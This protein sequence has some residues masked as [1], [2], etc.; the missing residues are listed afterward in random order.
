MRKTWI[1]AV[2]ILGCAAA[3]TGCGGG[4]GKSS[5]STPGSGT[6]TAAVAPT[7]APSPVPIPAK[8]ASLSDYAGAIAAYLTADPTAAGDNC[9][10]GLIAAWNM[11]LITTANGCISANTDTDP[12]KEVVAVI[13]TALTTPGATTD[14][15]FE[16][17][18][19][20]LAAG[21]YRVAYESTSNDVDPPGSTL[22][23]SPILDAGNL[24]GD[25]TGALAY[26]TTTCGASTCTQTVHILKG[27]PDGY[28]SL[29]PPDGISMPSAEASFVDAS[30]NGSK[31]LL[32]TGGAVGSVGGGPQRGR[33]ETWAYNGTAYALVSTKQ[34]K[35]TFLYHAVKD[36]DA[37]FAAGEYAAAEAAYAAV[38]G[39]TSLQ[40]WDEQK[41]ERNELESYSLF[42]AAVA[43]A[44]A[45]GDSAK[46]TSYLDRARAYQPQTLHAQLAASFEAA[47]NAKGSVSVG[48]AAVRDDIS[49]NLAEY[50]AFWNFGYANP[51]FDAATVCPF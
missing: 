18:V 20:D 36:A 2:T 43:L 47:Y 16:V 30:G 40:V 45:G 27:T 42:R 35:P 26:M 3:A 49:A 38:V 22:P 17:V 7:P 44:E 32:L 34:E 33:T 46:I 9:L 37:L 14:T 48:C 28:V 39:D 1:V 6:A 12:E 13:T 25:G 31:E 10:A 5:T 15:Q 24:T 50:Q 8:P 11:P 21:A 51:P 4:S 19:F 29:A 23:I 41:N